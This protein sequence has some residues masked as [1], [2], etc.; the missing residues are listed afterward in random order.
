M[1]TELLHSVV[2]D[3]GRAFCSLSVIGPC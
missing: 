3:G 2:I 1:S